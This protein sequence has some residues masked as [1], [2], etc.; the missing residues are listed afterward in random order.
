MLFIRSRRKL[1]RAMFPSLFNALPITLALSVSTSHSFWKQIII[2]IITCALPRFDNAI[3]LKPNDINKNGKLNTETLYTYLRDI[4][5]TR[6][7]H[8]CTE[9]FTPIC[10][11]NHINGDSS[12]FLFLSPGDCVRNI[13]VNVTNGVGR[14]E[15]TEYHT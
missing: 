12:F 1:R 13:R 8:S 4:F 7:E 5:Y 9:Y 2:N 14:N 6:N 15:T 3:K 10:T 11:H